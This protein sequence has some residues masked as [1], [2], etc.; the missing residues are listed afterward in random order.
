MKIPLSKMVANCVFAKFHENKQKTHLGNLATCA[1][2]LSAEF[3]SSVGVVQIGKHS[4]GRL[5]N[6]IRL[7]KK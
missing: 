1:S 4:V 6:L 5:N 7:H 3:R 2:K